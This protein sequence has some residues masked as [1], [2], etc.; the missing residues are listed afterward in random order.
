VKG[1]LHWVS[2]AHALKAEVRVYEQLFSKE[3]PDEEEDFKTCLNPNSLESLTECLIEP[4][5]AGAVPGSR[6]QFLRHGYFIADAEDFTVDRPVFN[7]IVSLKDS[8]AK[9]QKAGQ[10]GK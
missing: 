8:W 5:L 9:I 7:R 4:S 10:A 6:Y 1:T 2:A 3:N